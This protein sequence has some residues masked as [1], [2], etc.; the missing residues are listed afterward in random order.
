MSK[1]RCLAR[2]VSHCLWGST[3]LGELQ[4]RFD[5]DGVDVEC[6]ADSCNQG[7]VP[8]DS[9]RGSN[10][11]TALA[12]AFEV[13]VR[14]FEGYRGITYLVGIPSWWTMVDWGLWPVWV[15]PR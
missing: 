6:F 15:S 8:P 4:D 5:T 14:A 2:E 11:A 1:P 12:G 10:I 3:S 13:D 7:L 9:E